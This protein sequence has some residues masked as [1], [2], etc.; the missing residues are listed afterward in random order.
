MRDSGM[1]GR[2]S[3]EPA[4][5]A[6]HVVEHLVLPVSLSSPANQCSPVTMHRRCHG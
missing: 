5:E 4:Q 1:L 2:V 6:V 3:H